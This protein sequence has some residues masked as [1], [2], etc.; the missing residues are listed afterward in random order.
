MAKDNLTKDQNINVAA[1]EI[2]FV[3]RFQLTWDALINIMGI[4]RPIKK[5]PGVVL[6][7]K[8]AKLTLQPGNVGEGEEIPY[9][10]AQVDEVSYKE[11]DLEKYAKAVS[12][13]AIKTHGYAVAVAKTDTAFLNELQ[14]KVMKS[15][16]DYLLTGTNVASYSTFQMAL[17]MAKSQVIS[18]FKRMHLTVTEVVAFCNVNDIYKYL[19]AAEITVQTQFGMTYVENFMGYRVIFLCGDEEIP[20]GTIAATPVDNIVMYYVDPS[21]DDFARAGLVYR[22]EGVTPLIGFHTEG[23]YKTAVSECY[24][25]MGLVLFAEYIDGIAVVQINSSAFSDPTT[26]KEAQSTEL[27]DYHTSDLQEDDVVVSGDSIF[28]TLKYVS[29][30]SLATTWGPGNFI[31]LKWTNIPSGATVRVG[32]VPS[33]GSGLVALDPDHNAVIKITNKNAQ[34]LAVETT[35]G[36]EKRVKYFDLS[37]LVCETA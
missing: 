5:Q 15:F 27:W 36:K 10:L 34:K 4:M 8:V 6:K 16:Y 14:G 11:M 32:V 13:E 19:G 21:D 30:G 18:E 25:L 26:S 17:A 2:D 33:E 22:T 7:S 12:I 37:G 1:R 9:S 20:Q 29:T 31:A 23:S 3:S 24:A 35:I 28:G